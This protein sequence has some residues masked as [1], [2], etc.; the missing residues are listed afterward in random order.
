MYACACLH[1]AL[2]IQRAIRMSH[3]AKFF[4]PFWFNQ[5]FRHYLINGTIFEKRVIE[6]KMCVLIFSTTFV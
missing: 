3:I 5:I 1:V 4:C 2:L 6:Y